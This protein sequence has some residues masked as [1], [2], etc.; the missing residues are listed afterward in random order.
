MGNMQPQTGWQ[1]GVLV[2]VEA[3]TSIDPPNCKLLCLDSLSTLYR[4]QLATSRPCIMNPCWVS[5]R[6]PKPNPLNPKP[7]SKL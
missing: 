3:I 1:R 4:A 6:T 7:A 5:R 2:P